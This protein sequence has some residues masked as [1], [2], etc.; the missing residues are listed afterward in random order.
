M[1]NI[2]IETQIINR[3]D[4]KELGELLFNVEYG[5]RRRGKRYLRDH[6]L[7]GDAA[8]LDAALAVIGYHP[9]VADI[10]TA[11]WRLSKQHIK[12]EQTM[13]EAAL[14]AANRFKQIM[15]NFESTES[16]LAFDKLNR[17]FVLYEQTSD[18]GPARQ[19][20][21]DFT[22]RAWDQYHQ[23]TGKGTLI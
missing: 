17:L 4:A 13:I 1:N 14:D 2:T 19:I 9:L 15:A 11:A 3:L 5:S 20:I 10:E 12:D 23:A 21:H 8:T 7:C 18:H 6:Q 16:A 22:I